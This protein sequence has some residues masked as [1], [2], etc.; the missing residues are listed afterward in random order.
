MKRVIRAGEKTRKM[1]LIHTPL[2]L[3]GVTPKNLRISIVFPY[4]S[5]VIV[6]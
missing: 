5:I 6:P 4:Y 2:G 3:E 1:F